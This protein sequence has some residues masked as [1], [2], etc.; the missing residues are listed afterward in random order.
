MS[1]VRQNFNEESEALINRQINM[2][3]YASYVYLAMVSTIFR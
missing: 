1:R 2:E 3:M